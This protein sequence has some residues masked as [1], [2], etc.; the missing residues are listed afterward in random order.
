M[1]SSWCGVFQF[2]GQP[3][4]SSWQRL[5]DIVH[6]LQQLLPTIWFCVAFR[7]VKTGTGGRRVDVANKIWGKRW[8][9]W[10]VVVR[11]SS[12]AALWWCLRRCHMPWLC[13]EG[14]NLISTI[15]HPSVLC[16]RNMYGLLLET[17]GLQRERDTTILVVERGFDSY[18]QVVQTVVLHTLSK[19]FPLDY[20]GFLSLLC[21]LWWVPVFYYCFL[22]V[23]GR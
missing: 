8:G 20:N 16:W 2:V 12:L 23:N 7:N 21:L 14:T 10:V 19:G 5:Q 1:S 13:C 3:S 9:R 18:Q 22:Q 4:F 11:S 17:V 15:Y 6:C